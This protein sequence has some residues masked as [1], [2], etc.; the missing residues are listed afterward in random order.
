MSALKGMFSFFTM[1]HLDIE[2]KD[3][4]DMN[5]KFYLAP[6]VGAFYGIIAA[7][8]MYSLTYYISPFIAAVFTLFVIQ[9]INR[10]LHIDGTIDVG[11]GLTVAGRREDHLRALKDTRIGAGGMATALFVVLLTVALMSSIPWTMIILLPFMVEVLAKNS[12][13]SAAAFG[14]PGDGMAGDSVRYT[15]GTAL[16]LAFMISAILISAVIF[17]SYMT[18]WSFGDETYLPVYIVITMAASVLTGALMSRIAYRNFGMTNGDVL[19]AT[20]EISRCVTLMIMIILIAV[21]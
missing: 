21:I 7:V 2:Q 20:N 11:D 13:V 5:R 8:L 1:I 12:M 9:G 10:F 19:G 3:M 18:G 4:D 17:A 16:I 15:K 6:L 14:R